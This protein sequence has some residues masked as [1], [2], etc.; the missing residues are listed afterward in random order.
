MVTLQ[1]KNM[2]VRAV[3]LETG[4]GL[5]TNFLWSW[6]RLFRTGFGL[7]LE[8]L[9]SQSPTLKLVSRPGNFASKIRV[10][11]STYARHALHE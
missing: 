1:C 10:I 6:S 5:E 8:Q 4:L 3:S 11:S 9:W 2:P 7:G